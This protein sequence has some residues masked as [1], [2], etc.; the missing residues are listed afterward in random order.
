MLQFAS[1]VSCLESCYYRGYGAFRRWTLLRESGP[2]GVILMGYIH[3]DFC[4]APYFLLCLHS[5]RPLLGPECL[6]HGLVLH[7]GLKPSNL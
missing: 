1:E 2:V 6:C 3:P 5:P 4:F 7:E